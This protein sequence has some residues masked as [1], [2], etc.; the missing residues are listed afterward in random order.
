MLA[1][2]AD[3]LWTYLWGLDN[4]G[5]TINGAVGHRRRRHRRAGGVG[6]AAAARRGS[7]RRGR[8]AASALDHEDLAGQFATNP[9]ESGAGKETNGVDDDG[10]G[11]VDD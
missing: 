9:G 1:Q 11:L 2:S 8:H 5:Q 3:T 6:L 4:A 10:N 7:R